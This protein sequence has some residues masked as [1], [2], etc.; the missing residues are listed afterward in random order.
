MQILLSAASADGNGKP[1]D[2]PISAVAV[3]NGITEAQFHQLRER[4]AKLVEVAKLTIR[5]KREIEA[6]KKKVEFRN[7]ELEDENFRLKQIPKTEPKQSAE[8]QKSAWFFS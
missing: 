2:K 1:D 8:A 7:A 3:E 5:Q 4:N 6:A